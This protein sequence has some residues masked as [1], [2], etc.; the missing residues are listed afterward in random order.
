MAISGTI[1]TSNCVTFPLHG[2]P[3]LA[4]RARSKSWKN[5]AHLE[6]LIP[7]QN[8]RDNKRQLTRSQ[9]SPGVERMRESSG[10]SREKIPAACS[11]GW[12]VRKLFVINLNR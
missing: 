3:Q 9:D 4:V 6:R 10:F 1:K 7:S 2:P 11:R 12:I 5:D 8:E